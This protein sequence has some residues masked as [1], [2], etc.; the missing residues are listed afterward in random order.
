MKRDRNIIDSL[1]ERITELEKRTAVPLQ[2]FLTV[3]AERPQVVFRNIFQM[4][5]DMMK[6]YVGEGVAEYPDDTESIHYIYYDCTKLF[7]E[8]T[9]H[10]FFA[11]R[12]FANRLMNHFASFRHGSQQ[13]RIY[14]FEGPHG[15]GKSTFLN[16]LL[17]K[18]EQYSKT[19]DG[20]TFE[21]IWRLNKKDL[22]LQTEHET[23][24]ILTQLKSLAEE[25]PLTPK[26][27]LREG[28]ISLP[29]K[30]YLEVPCPSHDHPL[31][32]IPKQ[33]R[34]EVFDKLIDDEAFK[35]QLFTEKQYEWVFR[36]NPCTICISL[37]QTLLDLLSSPHKVFEMVYARPY[38]FNRRLGQGISVFNPGDKIARTSIQTNELLQ[39]QINSLLKDSNR[40]KY[41]FSRY[42]NTNNGIYA[43]MD[44][45]DHNKERLS[46]LHGIISEGVH[47]VE[48]IE[49]NVNS[50]FLALMNPEDRTNIE[51]TQSF[52]DRISFI[53]IPYVLDYTTEV[54]IFVNI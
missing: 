33:Y 11:D 36:D 17:M 30:D 4:L 5:Y 51:G 38:E 40:V 47:K 2:E 31:L 26:K 54:K 41:L 39:S 46:N 12:L 9:D 20:M 15:C 49:E 28:L 43:L 50:L 25:S 52:I 14:I 21:T 16:D 37:Y 3:T 42:A 13:N 7:V 24:A 18:F 6:A 8:G 27:H 44:I 45:K 19:A 22:G 53:T 23:H 48:D 34:R 29:V 1:S 32:I 35:E 10:P